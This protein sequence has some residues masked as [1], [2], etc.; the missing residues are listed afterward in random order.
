MSQRFTNPYKGLAGPVSKESRPAAEMP[1]GADTGLSGSQNDGLRL[2]FMEHSID[3]I[4]IMDIHT[5]GV[6]DANSAFADMLGYT[7]EEVRQL[8]VWDWDALWSRKALEKMVATRDFL[9]RFETRHRRK[10]G[11]LVEV[12]ISI[13]EI[14]WQGKPVAFCVVRDISESKRQELKLQQE[15][16]RWQMLME[17][18]KDG[19]VVIDRTHSA[20]IDVNPAFA[21]MLGYEMGEM[22]GM[23][24]WDWDARFSRTEIEAMAAV[25]EAD[26]EQYFETCMRCKD[27]SLREV[28]VCATQ[29]TMGEQTIS[30]CICRDI[31]SRNL[32][33]KLLRCR[34][35]EFR[36]LAENTPDA[37]IRYDRRLHCLYVNPA[38]ERL[39]GQEKLALLGKAL[40]NDGP[41]DLKA[42]RTAKETA[43]RTGHKQEAEFLHQTTD[44]TT[45]WAHARFVPE[46]AE[47][48][49][50]DSVLVVVRDISD[51]VEQ[52]ELARQLAFTDTLTGLPN[53]AL[54][55]E[56][57]QE[58]SGRATASGDTFA[59]LMLDIDHFKDVNDTLGHQTGDELLRQD[60]A[61]CPFHPRMRHHRPAGGR[62]VRHP[63]EPR[64]E[65]RRRDGGGHPR[66]RS[67][68]PAFRYRRSG[69][70]CLRK[71]RHRLLPR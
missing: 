47:D 45:C 42:Y 59:L 49:T 64:P 70:A 27:G 8:K 11:Q 4:V 50:V 28:E 24:P 17:Q 46:F 32:A 58:A 68:D 15:L 30:I 14:H 65:S 60:D 48:G 43:F 63:G 40:P 9:N 33:E 12:A 62:R 37:I 36:S 21:R 44:G 13:T 22:I 6:I 10:D 56:R 34:E 29:M 69:T 25:H 39:L 26:E 54:F 5:A 3:G 55:K 19:I 41:F 38:M 18:S 35:Q 7:L 20:A 61:T 51:I 57:F 52:R 2:V 31:T 67:T 71:H 1:D 16:A 23:R 66:P 53:R